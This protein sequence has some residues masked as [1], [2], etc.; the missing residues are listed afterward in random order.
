MVPPSTEFGKKRTRNYERRRQ[1]CVLHE[2]L[3]ITP[4]LCF[5]FIGS[6][7]VLNDDEKS[8]LTSLVLASDHS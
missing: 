6:I 8:E 7:R 1:A 2:G 4:A 5:A 3:A